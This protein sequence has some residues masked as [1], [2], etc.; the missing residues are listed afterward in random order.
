MS[1]FVV[2]FQMFCYL[3]KVDN[4]YIVGLMFVLQ[5]ISSNKFPRVKSELWQNTVTGNE[6]IFQVWIYLG[7]CRVFSNISHWHSNSLPNSHSRNWIQVYGKMQRKLRLYVQHL[8][9]HISNIG[10]NQII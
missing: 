3:I 4:F 5:R 7:F 10:E 9:K 2:L 1:C 8:I 6:Q